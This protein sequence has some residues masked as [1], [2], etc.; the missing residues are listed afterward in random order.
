MRPHKREQMI[1][2][3]VKSDWQSAA[4]G[5]KRSG[6]VESIVF[7]GPR[8]ASLQRDELCR[9]NAGL[10]N[11]SEHIKSFISREGCHG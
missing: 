7:P 6:A 5:M 4:F 11:V 1:S 10:I 8:C 3:S 9:N 2:Q